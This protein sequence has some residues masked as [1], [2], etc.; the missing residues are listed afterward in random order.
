M[1][2]DRYSTASL[3][4]TR[5]GHSEPSS[6]SRRFSSTFRGDQEVEVEPEDDRTGL[7]SQYDYTI[8][9]EARPKVGKSSKKAKASK[10]RRASSPDLPDPYDTPLMA[11]GPGSYHTIS[12]FQFYRPHH[13]HH[14]PPTATAVHN[15]FYTELHYPPH[16]Q[17][18]L[19]L[20]AP[21]PPQP[22]P[23]PA[24]EMRT[25]KVKKA[26]K[27]NNYENYKMFTWSPYTSNG[28]ALV[29]RLVR[30]G[31]QRPL[32]MTTD[33]PYTLREPFISRK[34]GDELRF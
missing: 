11:M 1:F 33:Y 3:P 34:N 16:Q 8:H 19:S 6:I 25:L 17:P 23:H 21:P 31:G 18:P 13:H 14:H 32:T 9:S 22:E 28:L 26:N 15:P 2:Q 12:H 27:A 7:Y 30:P 10:K 24:F 5:Q 4:R 29:P 20:M